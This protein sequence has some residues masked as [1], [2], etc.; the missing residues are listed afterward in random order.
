VISWIKKSYDSEPISISADD[1][2]QHIGALYYQQ[3][4]SL[5]IIASFYYLLFSVWDLITLTEPLAWILHTLNLAVLCLLFTLYVIEKKGIVDASNIYLT[6]I[7]IAIMMIIN[8]HSHVIILNDTAMLLRSILAIFAFTI[9]AMLPWIFWLLV[10]LAAGGY[11][12]SATLTDNTDHGAMIAVGIGAVIIAYAGF[13]AK[14]N[15]VRTQIYLTIM[16]QK[17]AEK[18]ERLAKTKDE[19]IANMNHE[20]RTPLTGLTGMIDLLQS[21]P[22]QGEDKHHLQIAKNSATTLQLLINDI[23]DLSK[24]DARKLTLKPEDFNVQKLVSEVIETMIFS[25]NKKGIE[26]KLEMPSS[27]IP[28]VTGDQNRIRQ[29]L[30][31]LLSNA[32]KFTLEGQVILNISPIEENEKN[33]TL[34]LSIEDTGVGIE[35]KDLTRLFK[36]FEQ[37]DSSFTR[38]QLGTG[39][40]LTISQELAKLMGTTIKADSIAGKG[41][42]FSFDLKLNKSQKQDHEKIVADSSIAKAHTIF[43]QQLHILVAEDNAVNQLLIRK[44]LNKD[45][46]HTVYAD[47]GEQALQLSNQQKFDLILMDIQ[48]PKMSGDQV[49][50]EIRRANGTNKNTVIIGLTANYTNN[51]IDYYNSIGMEDCIKKPIDIQLFYETIAQHV[52]AH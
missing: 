5:Q 24:L 26:L 3:T 4:Y 2:R 12:I 38:K 49:V 9:V 33:I 23:L 42:R 50:K 39:L 18:M 45:K 22:L 28:M 16:N 27:D 15:S 51:D 10:S 7:P 8:I 47:D 17:R 37:V 32:I 43:E 35:P 25:A 14:Y 52:K 31:N 20:L 41:S 36:R 11:F 13:S 34:H 1:F 21:A 30:F 19:F 48:M 44:L 40:G 29:I 46:W 6:P